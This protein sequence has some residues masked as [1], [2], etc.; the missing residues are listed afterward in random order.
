MRTAPK[1]I[2]E[3]T[4]TSVIFCQLQ[5]AQVKEVQEAVAVADDDN[6]LDTALLQLIISLLAQETSQLG[7][8]KSLV[9][10][11]LAVRSVNV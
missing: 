7:L 10:H 6:E 4:K 5:L 8:Y 11:Y 3:E 9:M 1:S 2:D